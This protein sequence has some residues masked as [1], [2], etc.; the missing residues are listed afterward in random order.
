ME[1]SEEPFRH[2]LAGAL[3]GSAP[4]VGRWLWVLEDTRQLTLESLEGLSP[5][6]LDWLPPHGGNSI[7]TILYHIAAIEMDWLYAEVLEEPEPWPEALTAHFTA[8][9]RE[10]VG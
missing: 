1:M 6:A 5:A 10:R 8:G 7:G 4:E 3:E 2:L 9:V